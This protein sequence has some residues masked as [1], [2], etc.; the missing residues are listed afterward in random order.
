[1]IHEHAR[2]I[3]LA[4]TMLAAATVAEAQAKRPL[5]LDVRCFGSTTTTA[6]AGDIVPVDVS[7]TGGQAAYNSALFRLVLTEEDAT[8]VGYQWAFPFETGGVTDFSLEGLDL[9]VDVTDE[10]L[11][12]PGY[13]ASVADVEFGN[14][15][16][17]GTAEGGLMTTVFV[18]VPDG[19]AP[20]SSFFIV[21]VPDLVMNG[22]FP[23]NV[24]VGTLLT[25]TIGEFR[26][27]DL[28]R[29]GVVGANDLAVVLGAFGSPGDPD[30]GQGNPD[31]ND[32]GIVNAVDLAVLLGD[33]G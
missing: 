8:L 5:A 7:L 21:A 16:L 4:T 20:G 23:L 27:A 13:P 6:A 3:A 31:I 32:D 33:W 17:S 26:R 12:G 28:D 25:I 22:F 14:F 15:L 11:T 1:M 2:S 19:L 29:D 9:P 10:T 18:R 30:K 24:Q